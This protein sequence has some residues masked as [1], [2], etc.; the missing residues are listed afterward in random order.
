MSDS[1]SD[2]PQNSP[3]PGAPSTTNSGG[4][5]KSGVYFFLA[6]VLFVGLKVYRATIT[7]SKSNQGFATQELENREQLE[8]ALGELRDQVERGEGGEAAQRL[9]GVPADKVKKRQ[10]SDAA[11]VPETESGSSTPS[12]SAP[13]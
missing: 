11:P 7:A 1:L 2:N 3:A 12:E 6:I 8:R 10:A 5:K 13:E 4:I 9:F